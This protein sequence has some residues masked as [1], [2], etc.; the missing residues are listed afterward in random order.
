MWNDNKLFIKVEGLDQPQKVA[1]GDRNVVKAMEQGVA[2]EMKFSGNKT[3]KCDVQYVSK[4]V[5]E[6]IQVY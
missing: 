2:L 4:I 6:C 5:L 1:L 3:R